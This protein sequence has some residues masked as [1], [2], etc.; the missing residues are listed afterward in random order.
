VL[1]SPPQ[2]ALDRD[3]VGTEDA[4]PCEAKYFEVECCVVCVIQRAC[5]LFLYMA[6]LCGL[7]QR[8]CSADLGATRYAEAV[9]A[10]AASG[11]VRARFGDHTQ[12]EG[13][14]QGWAHRG[15]THYGEGRERGGF[16]AHPGARRDQAMGEGAGMRPIGGSQRVYPPVGH[17]A[18]SHS[19]VC[20]PV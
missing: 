15:G 17:G 12:G 4:Q 19:L 8:G 10:G 6:E 5:I 13:T 20:P 1:N 11:P 9:G 7:D 18:S 2:L 14:Q 3:R 16:L